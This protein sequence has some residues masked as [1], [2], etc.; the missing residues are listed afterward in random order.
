MMQALMINYYPDW[1]QDSI[2]ERNR[3]LRHARKKRTILRNRP[4]GTRGTLVWLWTQLSTIAR[5][6]QSWFI[7]S[8]VGEYTF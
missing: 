7:V 2:V 5:A 6:G 8:L 1:I 4:P 3:R